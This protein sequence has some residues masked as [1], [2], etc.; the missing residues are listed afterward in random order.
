[1]FDIQKRQQHTFEAAV[2]NAKIANDAIKSSQNWLLVLG[3]AEMSFLGALLF[4]NGLLNADCFSK[5]LLIALLVAFVLFIVGSVVQYKHALG[6]AREYEHISN[7]ALKYLQEGRQ[8]VEKMP[9]ELELPEKQIESNVSANYL[10]FSS[11]ILV[12]LVTIGIAILIIKI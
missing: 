11:Y 10:I 12:I 7:T 9:E 1:M 6:M 3:L 2:E 8:S 5:S 4:R